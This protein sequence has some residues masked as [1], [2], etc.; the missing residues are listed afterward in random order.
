M[1]IR[2]LKKPIENV[3]LNE[4]FDQAE[5]GKANSII[6]PKIRSFIQALENEKLANIP[7][8]IS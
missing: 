6:P 2:H 3:L 8:P 7:N 1:I 5:I 4:V